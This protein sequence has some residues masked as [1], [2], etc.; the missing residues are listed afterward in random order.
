MYIILLLLSACLQW[1]LVCSLQESHQLIISG[2]KSVWPNLPVKS[3]ES[4]MPLIGVPPV[5]RYNTEVMAVIG[6][7]EVVEMGMS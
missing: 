7:D 2:L 5:S 3:E 6:R 1:C 4:D